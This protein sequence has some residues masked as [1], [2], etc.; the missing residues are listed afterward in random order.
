MRV[1]LIITI[2]TYR[3]GVPVVANQIS[4]NASAVDVNS[5]TRG[6][7]GQAEEDKQSNDRFDVHSSGCSVVGKNSS[8]KTINSVEGTNNTSLLLEENLKIKSKETNKLKT[9]NSVPVSVA[10]LKWIIAL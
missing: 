8:L 4:L 3:A 6:A 9:N 10:R 2:L 5:N 7:S 1:Y